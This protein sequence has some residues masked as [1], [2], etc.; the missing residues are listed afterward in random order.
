MPPEGEQGA[1]A[2]PDA[3]ES[4]VRRP[5]AWRRLAV[6]VVAVLALG[7]LGTGIA[8]AVHQHDVQVKKDRLAAEKR[9]AVEYVQAVRPLAARV[10]DA[11]QPIQDSLDAWAHLRPGLLEANRDVLTKSGAVAELTAVKTAL[12]ARAA[13]TSRKAARVALVAAVTD[14]TVA[15]VDLGKAARRLGKSSDTC[16]GC[17]AFDHFSAAETGW[18]AA[19]GQFAA[20]PPISAPSANGGASYG[21]RVPTI[22]GFIQTSDV[23]CAGAGQSMTLLPDLP[24]V[25]DV[26][27]NFPK[28]AR[29]LRRSVTSLRR[30]ALP[31]S[32]AAL[33]HRL[34]VEL[35][36]VTS[37][38]T[39]YDQLSAALR[40]GDSSAYKAA[41]ALLPDQLQ[42]LKTLSSTYRSLGVSACTVFFGV[43]EKK[44]ST[45]LR[46]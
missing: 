1:L 2:A 3:P 35:Q 30:V 14:L 44:G 37:L 8:V 42:A 10:F 43:P 46:A 40:K 41:L 28:L 26:E 31:H 45:Q 15:V 6:A 39:S 25:Q 29:I 22:G 17:L 27:R 12:L 20:V 5:R 18:S 34:D 19:L 32:R 21:R 4:A 38:A 9:A 11:V 33:S 23:V 7:S 16:I 36:S 24:A 13:P